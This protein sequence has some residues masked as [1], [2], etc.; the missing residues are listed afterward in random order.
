MSNKLRKWAV[1]E[2]MQGM[3]EKAVEKLKKINTKLE[4]NKKINDKEKEILEKIKDSI[5]NQKTQFDEAEVVKQAQA[6]KDQVAKDLE[7]E[8]RKKQVELD[9]Q[10]SIKKVKDLYDTTP[11]EPKAD[12]AK[13]KVWD[14]TE[15]WKVVETGFDRWFPFYKVEWDKQVY[16]TGTAKTPETVD[17][18]DQLLGGEEQRVGIKE[19]TVDK[20]RSTLQNDLAT[21]Q[22]M[23]ERVEWGLELLGVKSLDEIPDEHIEEFRR[24]IYKRDIDDSFYTKI[25]E[26]K[27][28][29]EGK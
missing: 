23:W 10:A 26:L 14:V 15:K 2:V 20:A 5:Q 12:V 3:S 9:K 25:E 22:R 19:A 6:Q 24:L 4:A 16:K 29:I 7:I 21:G 8:N 1:D 11:W 28:A 27:E 18:F 17:E 13:F